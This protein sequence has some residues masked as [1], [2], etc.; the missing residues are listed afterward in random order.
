M[1]CGV[2]YWYNTTTGACQEFRCNRGRCDNP[3]CNQAFAKRRVAMA[4]DLV[5]QYGLTRFFTLTV[6][7]SMTLDESW[8]MIAHWWSLLRHRLKRYCKQRGFDLKYFAILECHKDGYP[9]IH[10]FWNV[11]IPTSVLSQMW[12]EVAPGKMVWLEVVTDESKAA[13][14]VSKQL[15]V[16]KYIGKDQVANASKRV[17]PR[18]RTMWRSKGLMTEFERRKKALDSE[19][20]DKYNEWV[21]LTKHELLNVMCKELEHG[22]D[23]QGRQD[24]ERALQALPDQSTRECIKDMEAQTCERVTEQE[25]GNVTRTTCQ[26]QCRSAQAKGDVDYG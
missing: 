17:Q 15:E 21:P 2:D 24:V 19:A 14:Y 13:E 16:A 25:T 7:R 20:G 9:H 11:Y 23:E 6:G 4:T 8:Q 5:R 1:K 10:G 18:K 22:K 3:E 12:S 26:D